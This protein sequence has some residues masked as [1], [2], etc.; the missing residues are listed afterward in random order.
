MVWAVELC[1]SYPDLD[2]GAWRRIPWSRVES[3]VFV[4]GKKKQML[5][6]TYRDES[7]FYLET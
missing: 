6:L 5:Q 3:R 4:P 7:I 2:E 1:P